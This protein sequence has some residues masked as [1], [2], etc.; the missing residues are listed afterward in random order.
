VQTTLKRS[1]TLTGTGLHSGRPA[2][3]TLAPA[4]AGFGIWFRRTDVT[5]GDPF[6]P[7][8]WSAVRQEPLCT[9]LVNDDGVSLGTVEHLMAALAGCGVHNALIDVNGPEVPILDGSAAPFAAAILAAGVRRLDAALHA[10][11]VLRPVEVSDG[12]A[13][14]RLAPADGLTIAFEIDFP[15]AAIGR[16]TRT[17][18]MANGAFL[19]D[20]ADSRTFCRLSDVERMRAAGK[21]LGGT[22]QNAVVVEGARVLTTGGLRHA[23]EPVRHKMLDALGDLALAG[24][25]ILGR[26]TGHRSGHALTNAL[27]RQ[28]FATPGAVTTVTVDA[29]MQRR[30]PGVGVSL[31]DLPAVA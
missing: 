31:A 2:T 10:L 23:D 26:F 19:H 9:T 28:L 8:I 13:R 1:I 11:R 24:A 4:A 14:A 30:L 16:Q 17:L 12:A 15:D 6:L 22:L 18:D 25:P 29:A 21:G 5:R 20:L 7:A 3:I 27:L